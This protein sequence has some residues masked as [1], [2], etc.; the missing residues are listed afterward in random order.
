LEIRVL[1]GASECIVACEAFQILGESK[2]LEHV[3]VGAKRHR[4]I[5]VLDL[6]ERDAC[7]PGP[8]REH[9]GRDLPPYA[10]EPDVVAD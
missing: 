5:A 10:R 8:F 3:G 7:H 9:R 4:W 6:G 1:E 2:G